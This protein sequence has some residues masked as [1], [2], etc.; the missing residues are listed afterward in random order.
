M[1]GG[2]RKKEER[3]ICQIDFGRLHGLA[4]RAGV[5]CVFADFVGTAPLLACLFLAPLGKAA[6]FAAVCAEKGMA[7]YIVSRAAR[8]RRV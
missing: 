5:S 1:G 3:D 2:E 7:D 6:C 4:Q 8:F